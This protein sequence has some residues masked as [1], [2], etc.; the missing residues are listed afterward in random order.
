MLSAYSPAAGARVL[1]RPRC[2]SCRVG[3][4][5]AVDPP[6]P[7]RPPVRRRRAEALAFF[8]GMEIPTDGE[9]RGASTRTSTLLAAPLRRGAGGRAR[10][11][12]RRARPAGARRR[13]V[14]DAE[15]RPRPAASR[16]VPGRGDAAPLVSVIVPA[17]NEADD[18]RRHADPARRDYLAHARGPVPVGDRRRRRRQHRRDRR[19]RR[20]LRRGRTRTCAI[21]HHRVNF[22]L[23][24]ALRYAF[25][26]DAGRLRRGHRLRP[27]LRARPPRPDA[28]RDRRTRGARIVIASP[29]T[30]GGKTTNIPFGRRVLSR[31]VNWLLARG[32]GRRPHDAHRDGAGLRRSVPPQPRPAGDGHRDQ[33]RDHLQGPDPARPDRR[34]PGPPR[35]VVRGDRRHAA[36]GDEL[37]ARAARSRRCSRRSCSGRSCSSCSRA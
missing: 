34:D 22:R 21:L 31:G 35:L 29:Y 14:R 5:R 15:R 10:A 26:S 16:A 9:A 24:Q 18:R 2:A 12:A 28:R 37:P 17:Y 1:R 13:D 25:G 6:A 3:R 27:Q 11:R 7:A 32:R 8:P 33:H 30:K 19:A 20:R 23:G 36:A 4:R